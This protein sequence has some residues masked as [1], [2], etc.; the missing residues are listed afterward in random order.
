VSFETHWLPLPASVGAEVAVGFWR[1]MQRPAD[2]SPRLAVVTSPERRRNQKC[3]D[4]PPLL[5]RGR[6]L[7][8]PSDL[9]PI[10]EC[11]H[12]LDLILAEPRGGGAQVQSKRNAWGARLAEV[13]W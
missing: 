5:L 6:W 8:W 12:P 9:F 13:K 7:V 3:T 10:Q 11:G 4:I 1:I 2:H